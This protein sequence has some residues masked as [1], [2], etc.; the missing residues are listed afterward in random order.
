MLKIKKLINRWFI[1]SY[2]VAPGK[3]NI[4]RC[5]EVSDEMPDAL[6]ISQERYKELIKKVNLC[7]HET[8]DMIEL[9][10]NISKHCNHPNELAM[11]IHVAQQ[12]IDRHTHPFSSLLKNILKK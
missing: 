5:D 3:C 10:V 2:P 12:L 9:W 11:C 8:N 4:V 1:K 7:F 6:G